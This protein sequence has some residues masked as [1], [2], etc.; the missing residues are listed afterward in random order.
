[1]ALLSA[2]K[3]SPRAAR[4]LHRIFRRA[5]AGNPDARKQ[6]RVLVAAQK[7]KK[8]Q[9]QAMRALVREGT[10]PA[11]SGSRT[12]RLPPPLP[13]LPGA[14]SA[15]PPPLLLPSSPPRRAL[16]PFSTWRRGIV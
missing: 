5:R 6:A 7:A 2:A 12:S 10:E 15:A 8:E 3:T 14:V 4:R 1:V 11:P 13:A 16:R 9:D